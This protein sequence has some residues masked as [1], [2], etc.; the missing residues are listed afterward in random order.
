M[1]SIPGNVFQDGILQFAGPL[2]SLSV[3]SSTVCPPACSNQG[4]TFGIAVPEPTTLAVWCFGL[5]AIGFLQKKVL[6]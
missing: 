3:L 2:N 6:A 5:V 4:L 1:L